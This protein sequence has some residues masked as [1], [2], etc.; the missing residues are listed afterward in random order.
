MALKEIIKGRRSIRKLTNSPEVPRSQ[1][2]EVIKLALHAPSAFNMQSGRLVVL[3]GK[4]HEQLWSIVT[5]T[6][7][8]HVPPEKFGPTEA[9]MNGFKGGAGTVLFFEDQETVKATQEK[10]SPSYQMHFHNWSHQGSAILQ[11]AIWLGLTEQGL[12]ASLQHYNPIIDEKVGREWG[13][14]A[15]W[16]LVAQMP[17]GRA[18][19]EPGPR[20]FLPYEEV[21]KWH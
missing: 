11:Y 4:N 6:L 8:A 10:S 3:T 18:A 7:R 21:V 13:I 9:R 16:S 20:T 15:S 2:E 1:I 14:P 19:E 5:E 17:F 12:A